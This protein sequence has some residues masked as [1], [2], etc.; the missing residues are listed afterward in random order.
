L[1]VYQ[2]QIEIYD[3]ELGSSGGNRINVYQSGQ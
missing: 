3:Y 2:N 1:N